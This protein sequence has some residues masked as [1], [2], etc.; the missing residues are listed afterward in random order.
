MESVSLQSKELNSAVE[1]IAQGA[2]KQAVTIEEISGSMVQIEDKAKM[3]ATSALETRQLS[4]S[5]SLSASETG[6]VINETVQVLSAISEEIKTIGEIARQ[7]NLLAINA[8]IEAARAGES[9]KGFSVVA[10]EVKRLAERSQVVAESIATLSSKSFSVGKRAQEL[11]VVLIADTKKSADLMEKVSLGVIEQSGAVTEINKAIL[12]IDSVIQQN[13]A[14]SEE[15][16]AT[17]DSLTF[18][19]SELEAKIEYFTTK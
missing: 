4:A 19:A 12:E 8:A 5:A 11:L 14:F 2:N 1:Q 17:A 13:A 10:H 6:L 18:H 15:L 7:T 3:I 16:S 9:G